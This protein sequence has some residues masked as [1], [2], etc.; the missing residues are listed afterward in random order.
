MLRLLTMGVAKLIHWWS[1][2]I[3]SSGYIHHHAAQSYMK[4][5]RGSVAG[6]EEG[7]EARL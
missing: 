3:I 4:I 1:H 5:N 2:D 7:G 6:G